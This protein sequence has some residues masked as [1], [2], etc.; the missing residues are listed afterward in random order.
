[1]R[2]LKDIKLALV[3]YLNTKPFEYGL[4]T[5]EH[6]EV[7]S[8][9]YDNPANCVSLF[10]NDKVDVALVPVGALP[11]LEAYKLITNTCIGCDDEVRTVVLMS[12][13]PITECNHIILD[14]HSRTSAKL[15]QVLAAQ[16]WKI[17]ARFSTIKID[18]LQD[19][20]SDEAVLMIGDKVFENENR[21][22]YSYD[23]GHYWK[24][25]T[26]LPFAYAVWIAKDHV[27]QDDIDLLADDL[28]KGINSIDQV[29][30]EQAQL[31]PSHDLDSYYRDNIDYVFDEEKKKALGL[32]LSKI[33][34]VLAV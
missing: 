32:F 29:I 3:G 10:Q 31:E 27:S 6:K 4:K 20:E 15:T 16:Y 17:D 34:E 28:Q 19:L 7:Y 26:G 22:K 9:Y 30:E 21:F 11:S 8:I 2:E 14:S 1:M 5:S 33:T 18:D 23:L 12:N 24:K 25:M 13:L